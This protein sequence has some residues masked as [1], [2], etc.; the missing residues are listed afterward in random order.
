[1]PRRT[2]YAEDPDDLR[3]KLL[4]LIR[5]LAEIHAETAGRRDDPEQK[6]LHHGGTLALNNLALLLEEQD[7]VLRSL[8]R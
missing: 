5:G 6:M 8:G 7:F 2:I 3:E 1:M 4:V